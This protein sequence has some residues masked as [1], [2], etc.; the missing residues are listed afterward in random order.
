MASNFQ[1]YTTENALFTTID[2]GKT[3]VYA[4]GDNSSGQL[5]IERDDDCVG[6]PTLVEGIIAFNFKKVRCGSKHTALIEE[7]GQVYSFGNNKYGQIGRKTM[8]ESEIQRIPVSVFE[9][10]NN[11]GNNQSEDDGQN[12]GEGEIVLVKDISCF[13]DT[14][15]CLSEE[16][17]LYTWGKNIMAKGEQFYEEPIMIG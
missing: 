7:R 15:I 13:G 17:R 1:I 5:G 12:E 11:Y 8:P 2:K 10:R 9:Q 4:W 6:V 14:T 16:N 3:L